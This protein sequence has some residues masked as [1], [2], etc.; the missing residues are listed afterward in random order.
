MKAVLAP[1]GTRGDV[2]PMLALGLAL[3]KAGHEVSLCVAEN[4]RPSVEALG[5]PYVRGGEDA[6]HLMTRREIKVE[7]PLRFTKMGRAVEIGRIM[8]RE[9]LASL[10]EAARGA[11][12]IVGTL[13][14]HAAPSV[15]E[16]LRIPCF[17]ACYFPASM[18]TGELPSPLFGA[19]DGPRWLHRATWKVHHFFENLGLRGLV[20]EYRVEKNLAPVDD[21]SAHSLA[22]MT[23]LMAFDTELAPLPSDWPPVHATGPW[24]LESEA[25][26]PA[27]VEDFL[28]AGEKP[29]YI[30]FGSVPSKD[31]E[32]RTAIL[33]EAI[34]EVG[35]RVLLAS[36]A[37]GISAGA[38]NS[39]CKVIAEVNHAA[40]F[41]RVA[42]V[43]HHGGAG[44]TAAA[45]RA[46]A[47]QIVVPHMFDQHY[48]AR[49]VHATGLGPTPLKPRFSS[50]ALVAALRETLGNAEMLRRAESMAAR[51]PLDGTLRAVEILE[52]Q[53][54]ARDRGRSGS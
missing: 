43:V 21:V 19:M 24:F 34:R 42:A 48:W 1:V 11:D 53:V 22:H 52:Q 38:S 15:A 29:V 10:E 39:R 46:G 49:R 9:Q 54:S 23:M 35:C 51:M 17:R 8:M 18:P 36:G 41:P 20:N 6:Q 25:P 37:A 31:P 14:S 13:L 32:R 7:G 30:G 2:Q 26:L 44:V 28:A 45:V 33:L 16:Y 4:F 50:S 12:M 3:V 27:D 47:P 5:L 40:L